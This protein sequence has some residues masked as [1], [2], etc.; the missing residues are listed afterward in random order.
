MEEAGVKELSVLPSPD[1]DGFT[2][3]LVAK[4]M[5]ERIVLT[6]LHPLTTILEVK[7]MLQE[8]TRILVKRQ[9]LVGLLAQEGGAK[10]VI[11]TLTLNKLKLKSN[12]TSH[13]FILMGTPEE[14]IFVD[15][16]DRDE[17]TDV[18]DDFEL[19]FNAGSDEWVNHVANGVKLAQFT[20]ETAVH[21]MNPPRGKP[22]LVRIQVWS[23]RR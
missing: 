4:F 19:D 2:I 16:S 9:K 15:P 17:M 6:D 23:N 5:K 18:I 14:H 8:R 20:E 1:Y 13:Q 11:D 3:S 10:G 12:T 22:L 7:E 21:I